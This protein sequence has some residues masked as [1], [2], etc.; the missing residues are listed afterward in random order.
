MNSN[1]CGGW[2]GD[3]IILIFSEYFRKSQPDRRQILSTKT[4]CLIIY[5]VTC[6][7]EQNTTL[8]LGGFQIGILLVGQISRV[9]SPPGHKS[10]HAQIT[11]MGSVGER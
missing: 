8:D 3:I 9:H 2:G 5:L 10:L 6:A 7:D 1:K 11:T 4:Q